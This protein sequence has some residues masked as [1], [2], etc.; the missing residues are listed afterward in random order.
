M[1][2]L[3]VFIVGFIVLFL[4]QKHILG[5][6]LS[7]PDAQILCSFSELDGFTG[8]MP[9]TNEID[10]PIPLCEGGGL[11]QNM[12]WFGFIA[13]NSDMIVKLTTSN[14]QNGN[15]IQYG[16]YESCAFENAVVCQSIPTDANGGITINLTGLSPG[17]DYFFFI[18]GDQGAYCDY[19][20]RVFSQPGDLMLP[21][22]TEVTCIGDNCDQGSCTPQPYSFQVQGLDYSI[23]YEWT[24][25]PLPAG[26]PPN[27][28]IVE[29]TNEATFDL[30]GGQYS[31]CVVAT[32]GCTSTDPVCLDIDTGQALEGSFVH[33]KNACSGTEVM[34][35]L[36]VPAWVSGIQV[37]TAVTDEDSL[38][39]LTDTSREISVSGNCE[40]RLLFA[41]IYNSDENPDFGGELGEKLILPD[42][43]A[44]CCSVVRSSI[45]F[46]DT[47][48]PEPLN[49]PADITISC[50]ED[51]TA[52][53]NLIF[54]DDCSG[55]LIAK[56][57]EVRN[58]TECSGG[59][60]DRIWTTIDS[61]GNEG[62][63][64]MKISLIP[65][66][67]GTFVNPPADLILDCSDAL[68]P[69]PDLEWNG[70][71]TQSATVAGE[72]IGA[73]DICSGDTIYYF[74]TYTDSCGTTTE[75]TQKLVPK[76]V[77]TLPNVFY[78]SSTA[79]NDRFYIFSNIGNL[80]IDQFEIYNRW[81]NRVFE[82]THFMSN[83]KEQGWD[84][85]IN[86]RPAAEGVYV[87]F[88]KI[89]LPNAEVTTLAGDI[90]LMN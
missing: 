58:V 51:L 85:T 68:P 56:P 13:G 17:E 22:P 45:S 73:G 72:M 81:G 62:S 82:N 48:P 63:Y 59:T 2:F 21:Q 15:L 76:P 14:C 69:I 29:G 16:I 60:I 53:E 36:E 11:P 3:K 1:R 19:E 24:I 47:V 64:T 18:D 57:V 77:I 42:C 61:C 39:V 44:M 50:L 43:Q 54:T 90:L 83:Q 7:C 55:E 70:A 71:C 80:E 32:N 27:P 88:V 78:P 12:S 4:F 79:G 23:T 46:Q 41:V 49:P 10:E 5:Q 66:D 8:T 52:L 65:Q 75:Y 87:Y 9:Q 33:N 6:S 30:S 20:I 40:N 35:K 67:Q 26:F 28:Q 37:M 25:E 89:T 86:G 84:G 74:W 34:A 38:I 31:I